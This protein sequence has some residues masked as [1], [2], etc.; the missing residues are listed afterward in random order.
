[1][2]V[3]ARLRAFA[4]FVRRRSF[5]GAAEELRISQPAVSRH[6]ADLELELGT[7]LIDRRSGAFTASGDLLA[8]HL[9]RAEAILAQ[10]AL[11]IGALREPRS[12]SLS[13]RAAGISGTYLLPEVIA[14]FQQ[15]HPGVSIDFLLGTSAEVVN[16]VRSHQAEI[17]VAGGF[18]AAPEIEAEP[19]IEDEVVIVGHSG[20]KGRRLSR[21]DIESFT[22]ISR[23]EGSATRVVADNALAELGIVP[24]RRL[25]LPAWE[26]I[27]LAVRRG[28]GIAAMSRI[29]MAEELEAG[30]LVIIPFIPWKVRRTVSIIRIRDAAL[31]P[32][33]HRFLL[34][35]RAR[36]GNAVGSPLE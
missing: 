9:L 1:M 28:H 33:A 26:S 27:K 10:A 4:G 30:T 3:E 5:S 22:W 35:L 31:T 11:G 34:M 2:R 29:A 25:A 6:I 15:A 8:S 14:E 13:V 17:G 12:G 32:T 24:K 23:E 20:L 21:D 18:L 16:A 36:C 19:L 7:T